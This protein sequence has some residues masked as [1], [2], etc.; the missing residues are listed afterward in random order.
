MSVRGKIRVYGKYIGENDVFVIG[1]REFIKN[2]VTDVCVSYQAYLKLQ[3]GVKD[4]WFEILNSNQGGSSTPGPQGPQGERG[5]RGERGP[6]GERGEQGPP[7]KDGATPDMSAFENKI[8]KQYKAIE[9]KVDDHIENHLQG[10]GNASIGDGTISIDKTWSS[11][12]I[13]N[14][15]LTNVGAV[16]QDI[17]GSQMTVNSTM[18]GF[19]REIEILG[20]TVQNQSDLSDIQHVGMWNEEKQGYEIEVCAS[21][22]SNKEHADYQEFKTSIILPCQ[23]MKIG[24][25]ADRLY[26]DKKKSRYV[27]EKNITQQLIDSISPAHSSY[28]GENNYAYDVRIDYS[29]DAN[30]TIAYAHGYVINGFKDII[31]SYYRSTA[32]VWTF[33]KWANLNLLIR[34]PREDRFSTAQ[35]TL[36]YLSE[37]NICIYY[38]AKTPELINTDITEELKLPTYINNTYLSANGGMQGAIKAKSPVDGGKVIGTLQEENAQLAEVN[39]IQ[40]KLINTTMLAMDEMYAMLEPMLAETLNAQ[41]SSKLVNMYV[42]MV[43]RGLKEEDEIPV[44]YRDEVKKILA[45]LGDQSDFK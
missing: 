10:E 19:L 6:Q 32:D 33:D 2:R 27:I 11:S 1:G 30:H 42:A 28:V 13:E 26:W 45:Q 35:K 43:E 14:F 4:G 29:K 24:K 18:D 23:L 31:Y 44:R 16:W 38:Q 20:N 12:K 41:G 25:V 21:N 7:G 37:N 17:N 22:S 40:D 39:N 3:Q 9:K 15:V 36:S 5:E 34:F 8:N